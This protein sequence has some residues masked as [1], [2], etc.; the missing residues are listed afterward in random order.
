MRK[1]KVA[2]IVLV[3]LL[4]LGGGSAYLFRSQIRAAIDT[5]SGVD[6]QGI[7]T[8]TATLVI[9]SGD[10]GEAVATKLVKLGVTK[11]F[12]FTYKR[13]IA[14]DPKF[15]PGTFTLRK[16]MSA[17]S[18]LDLIANPSSKVVTRVTVKEG[19]RIGNVLKVL[20]SESGIALSDF[21]EAVKDPTVYGLPASLPNMDGYLFPATY[22]I[23]PGSKATDV[24]RM[25]VDRMSAELKKFGVS[26][27]KRHEVLTMASIVQKEARQTPDFYKVSRVFYNRLKVGMHLQS[28][29]TVSY[30]SGG[31]TVTTT[32]AERADGN[33]YNTYVHAGLPVGPIGAPGETAI[34][35][36]LHPADG[37]WLY[38]CAINLKTGETVFST[39]LAEHGRAVKKWQQWMRENPGWNG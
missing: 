31:T 1:G 13:I 29:A 2:A 34:D 27:A 24:V 30:G 22:E 8:G 20:S 11:D 37:S 3:A 5:I 9:E 25:M 38:F 33:L 36:A 16:Q 4:V 23:E 17:D 26:D 18:A 14:R 10:T 32:D 15:V 12:S 21:Q 6:Y 7:G 28:D 39:T 19:L 35:A